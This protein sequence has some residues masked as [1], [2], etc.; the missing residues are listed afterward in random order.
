MSQTIWIARHGNRQDF[1]DPHWV[2]TAD[3][4]CD[5]GLSQDGVR[6]AQE[7]GQ[8]L[9]KRGITHL[10]S[11]PFL[12]TLETANYIA[13]FLDLSIKIEPGLGEFFLNL[14]WL[15]IVPEILSMTDAA[16]RFP[17]IDTSYCACSTVRYPETLPQAKRRSIAT[18]QQLSAAFSGDILLVS[19]GAPISSMTQGILKRSTRIHCALCSLTKLVR[20][21]DRWTLELNGETGHLSQTARSIQFNSISA[22]RY[23]YTR[24]WR[25]N[26]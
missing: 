7:L 18:L 23:L 3:H 24:M 25:E 22:V 21:G 1:V 4:P 20:Q 26:F 12:R 11:S 8:H 5:P 2:K 17:R 10:F 6:Q 9:T 14:G 13:E 16:C 19:H 15:S